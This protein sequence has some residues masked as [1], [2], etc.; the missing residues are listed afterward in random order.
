MWKCLPQMDNTGV[1]SNRAHSVV[2]KLKLIW[3]DMEELIYLENICLKQQMKAVFAL[4]VI[5]LFE[6]KQQSFSSVE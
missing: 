1:F 3:P 2:M 5:Y 4:Y 6:T